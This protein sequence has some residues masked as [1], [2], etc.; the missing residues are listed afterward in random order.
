M[1]PIH[2]ESL[3][4]TYGTRYNANDDR[5]IKAS[6]KYDVEQYYYDNEMYQDDEFE[7]YESDGEQA[8]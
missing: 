7:D 4:G 2:E 3:S 6:G 5:K 8:E 1:N